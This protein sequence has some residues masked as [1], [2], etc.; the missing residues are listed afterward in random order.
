MLL[1]TKSTRS[2]T[3]DDTIP[4]V[5]QEELTLLEYVTLAWV[6]HDSCLHI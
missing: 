6:A 4:Q 3:V 5:E 1:S 2:E